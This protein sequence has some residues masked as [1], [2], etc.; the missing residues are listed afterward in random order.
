[1]GT[2]VTIRGWVES[3]D[4]GQVPLLREIAGAVAAGE[5]R[6]RGGWTFPAGQPVWSTMAFFAAEGRAGCEESVRG[7]LRRVAALPA[8]AEDER[9]RGLFRVSHE[10][11]GATEWQLRDGTPRCVPAPPGHDYLDA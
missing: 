8:P 9:V 5:R 1:M 10:R 2:H 7:M 3:G 4:D 6:Y 11:D